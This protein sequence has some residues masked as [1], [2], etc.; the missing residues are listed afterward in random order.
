MSR[1]PLQKSI[2]YTTSGIQEQ[3]RREINTIDGMH[4]R[5]ATAAEMQHEHDTMTPGISDE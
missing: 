2:L 1:L 3:E 5:K 4:N